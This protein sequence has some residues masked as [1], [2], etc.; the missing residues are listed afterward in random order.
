MRG[1]SERCIIGAPGDGLPQPPAER[2][3]GECA[4]RVRVAV[5]GEWCIEF[6]ASMR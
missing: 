4:V 2:V 5:T 3:D 1:S 6:A